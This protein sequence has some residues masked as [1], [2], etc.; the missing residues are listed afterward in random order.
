MVMKCKVTR[1]DGFSGRAI[2]EAEFDD[3]GAAVGFAESLRSPMAACPDT[4][5]IEFKA[6]PEPAEGGKQNA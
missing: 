5:T 3:V 6:P 4:V 2:E 1:K